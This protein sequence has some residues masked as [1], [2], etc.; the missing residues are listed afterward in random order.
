MAAYLPMIFQGASGAMS[1][2]SGFAGGY[3]GSQAAKDNA[4]AAGY[5]AATTGQLGE[6]RAA[7]LQRRNRLLAGEQIAGYG[8][9]G[10]TLE[11]SPS[12]VLT[13]DAVQGE[14]DALMASYEA[15]SRVQALRYE[16]KQYRAQGRQAR[17]VGALQGIFDP[18]GMFIKGGSMLA[19]QRPAQAPTIQPGGSTSG[20]Y[21][22]GF[23]VKENLGLT[24]YKPG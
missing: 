10:V 9:S 15:Q 5:E 8:A 23:D 16:S 3:A 7:S 6:I 1:S 24:N 20:G 4:K 2:G 19:A 17:Y 22:G 11:G 21:V 13:Q 14:L 12:D 18:A